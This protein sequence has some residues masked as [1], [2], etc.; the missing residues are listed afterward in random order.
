M[1]FCF[2]FIQHDFVSVWVFYAGY[3]FHLASVPITTSLSARLTLCMSTL[4]T[5]V[6][7]LS[8]Y[9]RLNILA[10]FTSSQVSP[11]DRHSSFSVYV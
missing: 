7:I 8:L 9:V 6:A 4:C 5:P 1:L 11:E 3:Y 2:F 10:F